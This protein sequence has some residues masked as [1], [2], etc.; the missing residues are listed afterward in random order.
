MAQ[1]LVEN[2][3]YVLLV[4]ANQMAPLNWIKENLKAGWLIQ[5]VNSLSLIADPV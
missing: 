4:S 1:Y 2:Y 3:A 5:G